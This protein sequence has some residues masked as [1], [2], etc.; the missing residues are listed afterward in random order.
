MILPD[1]RL[2][3]GETTMALPDAAEA[4]S[5]ARPAEATLALDA[6]AATAA[7]KEAARPADKSLQRTLILV[8]VACGLLIL[9]GLLV[10]LLSR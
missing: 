10:M 8:N 4:L 1:P 2:P 7:A 9:V 6:D 3:A 5:Q